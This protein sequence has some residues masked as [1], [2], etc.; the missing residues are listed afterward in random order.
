MFSSYQELYQLPHHLK[1]QQLLEPLHRLEGQRQQLPERLEEELRDP[2]VPLVPR[3]QR[4]LLVPRDPRE[5]PSQQEQLEQQKQLEQQEQQELS[6][7]NCRSLIKIA[8]EQLFNG[9]GQTLISE[10]GLVYMHPDHQTKDGFLI[11]GLIFT[12]HL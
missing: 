11:G 4:L 3:E 6:R 5:Q 2:L 10:V 8:I 9:K 7:S 1:P 12:L